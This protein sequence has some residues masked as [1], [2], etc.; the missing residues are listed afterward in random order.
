MTADRTSLIATLVTLRWFAV[1]GQSVAVACVVLGLGVPLP[2]WPMVAAI[3][4]LAAFNGYASRR[5]R[6]EGEGSPREVFA[7]IAVD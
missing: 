4:L 2:L 1:A 3:G 5:A 6:Q 7:H